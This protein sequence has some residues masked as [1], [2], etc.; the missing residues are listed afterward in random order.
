[1]LLEGADSAMLAG[2]GAWTSSVN[3]LLGASSLFTDMALGGG[4]EGSKMIPISWEGCMITSCCL[5][6]V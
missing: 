3:G 5:L 2:M 6:C 4:P 1:M